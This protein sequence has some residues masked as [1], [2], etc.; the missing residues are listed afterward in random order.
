MEITTNES[1]NKEPPSSKYSI[2]ITS[3]NGLKVIEKFESNVRP[4]IGEQIKA[5]S[6]QTYKI[7]DITIEY[8]NTVIDGVKGIRETIRCVGSATNN[9][10]F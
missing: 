4:Q 6:G 7:S 8:V 5:P 2:V 1:I 9:M 3:L 10:Y